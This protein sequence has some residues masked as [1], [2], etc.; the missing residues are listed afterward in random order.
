MPIAKSRR[1]SQQRTLTTW[2]MNNAW[3]DRRSKMTERELST[4]GA[5][6][7]DLTAAWNNK[8]SGAA[9]L[10]TQAAVDRIHNATNNVKK[11]AASI[12]LSA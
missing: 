1:Y 11:A 4:S 6:Q 12:D 10:A 8:I 9:S 7:S 3:R 2:Q 5:V